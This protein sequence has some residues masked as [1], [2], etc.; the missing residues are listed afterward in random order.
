[1]SS[2]FVGLPIYVVTLLRGACGKPDKR[3]VHTV[4]YLDVEQQ[5]IRGFEF[6]YMSAILG[7]S[8]G[9]NLHDDMKK[10]SKIYRLAFEKIMRMISSDRASNYV[11]SLSGAKS[12]FLKKNPHALMMKCANHILQSTVQTGL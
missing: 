4:L 3:Q 11:G 1:M 6:A 10:I 9:A 8:T 7:P 2:P 5:R 12:L